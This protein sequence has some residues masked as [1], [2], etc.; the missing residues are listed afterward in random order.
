V[1][2]HE[3][4]VALL[5]ERLTL[6]FAWRHNDCCSFAFEAVRVQTGHDA[7]ADERRRYATARGAARVIRRYGSIAAIA[8]TRFARVEPGMARRGDIAL[9]N[10]AA[11]ARESLAIIEGATLVAPGQ[12]GLVRVPRAAMLAAWDI[13]HPLA[14][15]SD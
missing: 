13:E 5:G 9:V 1:R 10:G 7:W 15:V 12:A 3:A 8:D 4:L 2:D 14:R 6:P 11:G